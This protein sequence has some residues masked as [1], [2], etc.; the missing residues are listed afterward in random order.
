[1]TSRKPRTLCK[2]SS[3][4]NRV[5]KLPRLRRMPP[6]PLRMD[7][8]RSTI[9]A[10]FKALSCGTLVNTLIRLWLFMRS[11]PS[12]L[13]PL[14]PW[15]PW[16]FLLPSSSLACALAWMMTKMP[17]T[18]RMMMIC[19][20]MTTKTTLTAMTRRSSM[21]TR[22]KITTTRRKKRR[23]RKKKKRMSRAVRGVVLAVLTKL[24]SHSII[25]FRHF[26]SFGS[27]SPTGPFVRPPTAQ[28]SSI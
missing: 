10:L 2:A 18:R 22:K 25:L 15:A 5:Q 11:R 13:A 16:V 17:C 23:R 24:I 26:L 3:L 21:K 9:R 14:Q 6:R 20:R 27:A 7:V 4:P 28:H 8:S 1:M 12:L 19:S